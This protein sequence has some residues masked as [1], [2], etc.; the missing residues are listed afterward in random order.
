[1]QPRLFSS[2]ADT[3]SASSVEPGMYQGTV[4]VS[5]KKTAS[6]LI[7]GKLWL[8]MPK[9]VAT[10]A[11]VWTAPVVPG[12]TRYAPQCIWYSTDGTRVPSTTEPSDLMR[13]RSS[14]VSPPLYIWL[15]V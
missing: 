3:A 5:R 14:G 6:V 7:G 10:G 11:W 4:T 12:R 1:M 2:A 15:G 8:V 9:A 13:T